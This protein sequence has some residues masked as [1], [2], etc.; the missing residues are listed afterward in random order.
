MRT[1]L[2]SKSDDLIIDLDELKDYFAISDSDEN[3]AAC[4]QNAIEYIEMTTGSSLQKKTW[5]V[6][7]DNDYIILPFGPV[8]KLLSVTDKA[9]NDFS[10]YSLK[11][12]RESLIVKLKRPTTVKIT[13]ESGYSKQN[14]PN[15][16]KKTIF[17]RFWDN[18]S[19]SFSNAF[20]DFS[21][22]ENN[23]SGVR[24]YG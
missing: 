7:H 4:V 11:R 14:L 10:S 6:I 9:G 20:D 1:I 13:Y 19:K 24:V 23:F 2:I 17:E 12:S 3:I 8:V 18:Y 21:A 16:L 5:K 22:Y 15:C